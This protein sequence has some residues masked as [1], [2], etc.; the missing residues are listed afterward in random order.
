MRIWE[1]VVCFSSSFSY[2]WHPSSIGWTRMLILVGISLSKKMKNKNWHRIRI[3]VSRLRCDGCCDITHM[4]MLFL[5]ITRF[6]FGFGTTGNPFDRIKHLNFIIFLFLSGN[7][8]LYFRDKTTDSSL[9]FTIF[10]IRWFAGSKYD[11]VFRHI[12]TSTIRTIFHSNN[13]RFNSTAS[14]GDI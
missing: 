4:H 3:H 11:S 7:T 8:I 9:A 5:W 1:C 10:T 14:N 6:R 12:H 2:V 13:F